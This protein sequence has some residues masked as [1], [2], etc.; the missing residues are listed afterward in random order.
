MKDFLEFRKFIT[1][2]FIQIIFWIGVVVIVIGGIGT[3]IGG[4]NAAY[5]G[6]AMVLMGV[7]TILVGP[8]A[9]RIYCEL[10]IV[11]FQIHAELVRIRTH[12][13]GGAPPVSGFPVMPIPP[14]T[15]GVPIR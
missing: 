6:G 7:L 2:L 5:G 15:P 10:L 8:L 11:V 13:E 9:W 1:P 3:M 4:A 12:T 14:G